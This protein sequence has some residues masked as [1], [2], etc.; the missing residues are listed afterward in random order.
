MMWNIVDL[1]FLF[2]ML[3]DDLFC[4]FQAD[5]PSSQHDKHFHLWWLSA[6]AHRQAAF[7]KA[8]IRNNLFKP[9]SVY[10]LLGNLAMSF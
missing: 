10:G 2:W 4:D 9:K 1:E 3:S 5:V 8:V 7:R 6:S